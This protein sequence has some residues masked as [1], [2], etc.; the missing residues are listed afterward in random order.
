MLYRHWFQ[1]RALYLALQPFSAASAEIFVGLSLS[2][3]LSDLDGMNSPVSLLIRATFLG[4][5][6]A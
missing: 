2:H 1:A 4:L 3:D 6:V 5:E